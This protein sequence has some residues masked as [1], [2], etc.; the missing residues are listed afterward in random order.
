MVYEEIRRKEGNNINK[1]K[2]EYDH[3]CAL[4]KNTVKRAVIKSAKSEKKKTVLVKFN[5]LAGVN[6][7]QIQYSTSN[8]FKKQATKTITIK[9][10]KTF[11]KTIKKLKKK[12]YYIR[13]RAYKTDSTESK[14]YGKWSKTKRVKVK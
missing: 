1:N 11:N 3:I 12:T 8:G 7:Y 14:V 2:I 5:K 10:N 9:G 13:A 4:E 6:G